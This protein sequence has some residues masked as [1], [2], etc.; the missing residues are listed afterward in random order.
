[1]VRA[2]RAALGSLSGQ[3]HGVGAGALQDGG[4]PRGIDVADPDPVGQFF[5]GGHTLLEGLAGFDVGDEGPYF[6]FGRHFMPCITDLHDL[7]AVSGDL[8]RYT[9]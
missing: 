2:A 3:R 7:G 8:H 1:M 9:V 6:A 4:S 5:N